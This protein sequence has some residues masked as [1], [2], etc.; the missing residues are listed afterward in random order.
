MAQVK[1]RKFHD[2]DLEAGQYSALFALPEYL[3]HLLSRFLRSHLAAQQEAVIAHRRSF[4]AHRRMDLCQLDDDASI[5][6]EVSMTDGAGSGGGEV[7]SPQPLPVGAAAS[8]GRTNK[9]KRKEKDED[10]QDTRQQHTR[11]K[12]KA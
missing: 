5:A 4:G 12:I 1:N 11:K 3:S 7:E 6:R 9:N 10:E 8:T 2:D